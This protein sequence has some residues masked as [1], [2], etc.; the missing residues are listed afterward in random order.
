M[1]RSVRSWQVAGLILALV[2]VMAGI[3]SSYMFILGFISK[4][5]V[6]HV[7]QIRPKTER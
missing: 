1:K 2:M 3:T 4:L 7:L 5:T 6:D